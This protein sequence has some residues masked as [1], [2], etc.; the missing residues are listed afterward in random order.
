[1]REAPGLLGN[2]RGLASDGLRMVR[3]R[4][5]LLAIEVQEEKAH[6]VRQIVVASTVLYLLT[7][8]TLLAILAIGLAL[9]PGARETFFGV[10]AFIFLA[11]GGLGV[12]WLGTLTRRRPVFS[13][14]LS[15]LGRDE[16]ALRGTGD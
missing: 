7:F 11:L 12:A 1:M 5:E 3:T 6:A 4:L 16:Q 14:T 10:L 13:D 9:S 8:G 2:V 15:T